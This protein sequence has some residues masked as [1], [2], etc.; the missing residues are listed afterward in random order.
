MPIILK[1]KILFF[2]SY[3][4]YTNHTNQALQVH[5]LIVNFVVSL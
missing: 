5:K 4:D 2:D 3:L 1:F